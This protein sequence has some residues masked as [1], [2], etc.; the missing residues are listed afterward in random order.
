MTAVAESEKL[1]GDG[2]PREAWSPGQG[3][4]EGAD[5]DVHELL[6]RYFQIID[7][8]L[9]GTISIEELQRS[10]E[11]VERVHAKVLEKA[12]NPQTVAGRLPK[13]WHGIVPSGI[14]KLAGTGSLKALKD[15]FDLAAES[16]QG[17][18]GGEGGVTVA[19]VMAVLGEKEGSGSNQELTEALRVALE[20]MTA[21]PK[22]ETWWSNLVPAAVLVLA[23]TPMAMG[24]NRELAGGRAVLSQP[25]PLLWLTI[26]SAPQR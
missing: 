26:R 16:G 4:D 22:A 19:A 1:P 9:S 10:L 6:S 23:T 14:D 12:A 24:A 8:D 11:L 2:A 18:E 25:F 21:E 15:A 20:V 17:E 3:G 5:D 7:R 13:R